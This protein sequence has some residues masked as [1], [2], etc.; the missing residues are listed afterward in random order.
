M[1]IGQ[2]YFYLSTFSE[3]TLLCLVCMQLQALP[4]LITLMIFT[5]PFPS[6]YDLL[7]E[8]VNLLIVRTPV[9]VFASCLRHAF[10]VI[11]FLFLFVQ[12]C[13][14][15]ICGVSRLRGKRLSSAPQR[16]TGKEA[17]FDID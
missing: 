17:K 9:P 4:L 2:R 16:L 11:L 15:K 12:K 8:R 14:P 3:D 7:N 1:H 10:F 6:V 5:F 13:D